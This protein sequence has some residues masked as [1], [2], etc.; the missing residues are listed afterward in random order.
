MIYVID[1]INL[2]IVQTNASNKNYLLPMYLC[3]LIL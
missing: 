1:K 2:T 3:G